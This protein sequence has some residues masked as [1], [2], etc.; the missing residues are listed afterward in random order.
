MSQAV[1]NQGSWIG[2]VGPMTQKREVAGMGGGATVLN[3]EP[4]VIFLNGLVLSRAPAV[5][6]N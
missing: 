6:L 3:F 2:P 5:I 1:D 4:T